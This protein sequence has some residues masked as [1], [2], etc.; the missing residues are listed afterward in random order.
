MLEPFE[1]IV[2]FTPKF[3]ANG[4]Q[5]KDGSQSFFVE[6]KDL[7][8]IKIGDVFRLKKALNV[9]LA[10]KND[11]SFIGKFAGTHEP[12]KNEK[13]KILHWVTEGIDVEMLLDN[14]KKII[15]MTQQNP[16]LKEGDLLYFE[17]FGYARIEQVLPNRIKCVFAHK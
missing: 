14:G 8:G 10:Q 17:K 9:N 13:K 16:E 15:A 3:E 12:E 1:L 6:K 5:I 2:Q 11:F 7:K 4:I